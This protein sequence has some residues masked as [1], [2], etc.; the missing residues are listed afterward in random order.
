[1]NQL[2][3]F[4]NQKLGRVRV[5]EK[6]GEPHFVLRDVCD[7]LGISQ[8]T[9]V[10]ERL[11]GDEVSQIHVTDSLGR[12]QETYVINESGLYNV[13]IRSDKP[14][15]K[16]FKKW[17]TSEVLP[18]IRKHG[19]YMTPDTLEKA[20][21]DPD[22]LIRLAT[23]LKDERALRSKIQDK[24]ERDR[25]K[26]LFAEAVSVSHTSILVGEL[27]KLLKQNGI[28]IGQNRLFKWLREEKYLLQGNMPS[29][30]SMEREWFE[31]VERTINN[32]DGSVRITRT[33][34]VTGKGQV[35]FINKFLGEKVS[36]VN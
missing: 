14:Q 21:T 17:I 11:D 30:Y 25:P 12:E 31:V 5:I 9:R 2:K 22:F 13:I 19:A 1:M 23:E 32:P 24:V 27:A 35:F 7:V 15:A 36:E 26:V 8:A 6:D 18:S 29:Q 16:Q 3:V 10:A 33:P 34:K 28:E 4:E 20:L